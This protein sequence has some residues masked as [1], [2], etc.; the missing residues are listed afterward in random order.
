MADIQLV[1]VP[2]G[3]ASGEPA[4]ATDQ[5]PV[6][7]STGLRGQVESNHP[8]QPS[9]RKKVGGEPVDSRA[10]CPVPSIE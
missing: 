7:E 10:I 9:F 4:S 2:H 8:S 1:F 3:T 5:T 6:L